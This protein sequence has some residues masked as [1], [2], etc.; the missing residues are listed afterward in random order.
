MAKYE[1]MHT[2]I[3]QIILREQ[4]TSLGEIITVKIGPIL[5]LHPGA[6]RMLCLLLQG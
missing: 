6:L 3:M 2:R 5:D 1:I 4:A